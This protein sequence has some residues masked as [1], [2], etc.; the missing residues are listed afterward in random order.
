[1]DDLLRRLI[2]VDYKPEKDVNMTRFG[3]FRICALNDAEISEARERATFGKT[4]D[5]GVFR[6]AVIAKGCVSPVW[7]NAELLA[8]LKATDALDAI[9]KRLLPGEREMLADSIMVLSGYG[10]D[11]A[12]VVEEIKN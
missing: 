6:A 4:T 5:I 8:G 7:D 12:K 11:E 3:T 10:G 9:T 2:D 1:M